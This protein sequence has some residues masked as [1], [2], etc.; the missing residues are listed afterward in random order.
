MV[1]GPP[2]RPRTGNPRPKFSVR[3][4]WWYPCFWEP[5]LLD[6]DL[7]PRLGEL[8][9]DGLG[10]GLGHALFDGLRRAVDQVLGLLEAEVGDLAD[11]LDDADLVR[12]GIREDDGELGLLSRRSRRAAA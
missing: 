6:V 5:Q 12:A 11:R 1:A 4:T 9:L 7:R 8:L 10:V 2:Y 3:C